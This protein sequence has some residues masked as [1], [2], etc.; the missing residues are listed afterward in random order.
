MS[1]ISLG[2]LLATGSVG[3]FLLTGV[4][5]VAAG[6]IGRGIWGSGTPVRQLGE[7][8]LR[9]AKRMC[10]TVQCDRRRIDTQCNGPHRK[11]SWRL[12]RMYQQRHV[13]ERA[14]PEV[15]IGLD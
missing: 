3:F 13:I 1:R 14:G 15:E 4:D 8:L 12:R 6:T 7:L 2:R 9:R 11:R 5:S 10:E